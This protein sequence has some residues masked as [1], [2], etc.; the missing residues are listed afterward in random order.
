MSPFHTDQGQRVGTHLYSLEVIVFL[1]QRFHLDFRS[2]SSACARLL[3]TGVAN[4]Q[5]LY[6]RIGEAEM[7]LPQTKVY[8]T[9]FQFL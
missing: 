2:E 6:F 9:K 7:F 1:L 4:I 8:P 5:T 3:S